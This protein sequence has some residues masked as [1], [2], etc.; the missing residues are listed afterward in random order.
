M[1][2][3]RKDE[4]GTGVMG[5]GSDGGRG[6]ERQKREICR[7]VGEI[8]GRGGEWGTERGRV[9]RK[10]REGVTTVGDHAKGR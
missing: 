10:Q 8:I 1:Q 3:E 6:G 7:G 4:M 5:K 9:S 2:R